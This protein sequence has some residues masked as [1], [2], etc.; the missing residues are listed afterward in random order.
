M[1]NLIARRIDKNEVRSTLKRHRP[2]TKSL[3]VLWISSTD[4][5]NPSAPYPGLDLSVRWIA[6]VEAT[7]NPFVI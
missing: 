3:G 7:A 5:P 6:F 1:S 2:G 4:D